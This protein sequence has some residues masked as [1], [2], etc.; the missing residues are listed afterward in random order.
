VYS[1]VTNNYSDTSLIPL[2]HALVFTTENGDLQESTES[3]LQ[4]LL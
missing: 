2:L 4:K 3:A 1:P